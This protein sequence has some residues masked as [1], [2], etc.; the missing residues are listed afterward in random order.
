M[1][2]DEHDNPPSPAAPAEPS[3]AKP[4]DPADPGAGGVDGD[5]R[6][7]LGDHLDELRKRLI[8]A[9]LGIVAGMGIGMG[10]GRWLLL[11]LEK[12][13]YDAM[14]HLGRSEAGAKLKALTATEAFNTYLRVSAIFGLILA[15][16]WVFYQLWKF[17]SVGLYS[18]ERRYVRNTLPFIAGLFVAGAMFFLFVVATPILQALVEMSDWLDVDM[19]VTLE[20]HVAFMTNMMLVFGITFQTP[21][22]VIV[23]AKAGLVSIRSFNRFRRHVV[24]AIL[25]FT[26]IIAPPDAFSMLALATPMW[27]LYEIGVLLAWLMVR[28]REG[29]AGKD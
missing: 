27:L 7:S 2:A 21:L 1:I 3:P 17:V 15:S 12:P 10:I 23:L 24:I 4:A 25:I 14:R 20:N 13:Y 8:Y 9:V 28:K 26:A 22:I 6:M 5:V 16:W 18:K 11:L 19:S 29:T